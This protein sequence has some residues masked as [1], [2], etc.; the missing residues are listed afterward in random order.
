[1]AAYGSRVPD[2]VKDVVSWVEYHLPVLQNP[3]DILVEGKF[4]VTMLRGLL[5]QIVVREHYP[6]CCSAQLVG[7]YLRYSANRDWSWYLAEGETHNVWVLHNF[8]RNRER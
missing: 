8:S 2:E 1:M 4:N 3:I 6:I 5:P 7:P